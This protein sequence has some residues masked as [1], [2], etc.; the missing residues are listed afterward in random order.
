MFIVVGIL[1]LGVLLGYLLRPV[2]LKWLNMLITLTILVL[3]F[4]LGITVGGNPQIMNNLG[5]IG[6]K[7]TLIATAGLLGSV[8]AAKAI[9][10]WI[11]PTLL[12]GDTNTTM[13]KP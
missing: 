8:V 1:L 4:L 6:L 11:K 3:L 9:Y 7:A 10:A 2:E 5:S 12:D 13:P